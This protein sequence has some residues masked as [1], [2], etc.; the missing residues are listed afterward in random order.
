MTKKSK[1][2]DQV[3]AP[4]E[5][6][7]HVT[8]SQEDGSLTEALP[9]EPAG[10][11][12][13]KPGRIDR[14]AARLGRFGHRAAPWIEKVQPWPPYLAFLVPLLVY[15]PWIR[16]QFTFWDTA[17][18][19]TAVI[20][21][22]VPHPSGYPLYVMLGHLASLLPF[23]TQHIAVAFCMATVPSALTSWFIYQML[24]RLRMPRWPA[25]A[26]CFFYV[27]N[28]DVVYHSTKVE[29]Y[30]F[31]VF[32]LSATLYCILRWVQERETKWAYLAVLANCLALGGH[33]TSVTMI[34][35]TVAALLIGDWRRMIHP[36]RVGILLLIAAACACIY[37]YL[38]WSASTNHGDKLTWSDPQT[39]EMFKFHVTGEQYNGYRKINHFQRGVL[40]FLHKPN[41]QI[42]F[43]VWLLCLLGFYEGLKTQWK[44]FIPLGIYTMAMLTYVATYDI[45]DIAT[46]YPALILPGVIL[47]AIGGLWLL[48]ARAP[49]RPGRGRVLYRTVVILGL[50]VCFGSA[51]WYYR[52]EGYREGTLYD[53]SRETAKGV[54]EANGILFTSV[55][56]HS[57]SMWYQNYVEHPDRKLITV[58]LTTSGSKWYRDH[59]RERYPQLNWPSEAIWTTPKFAEWMIENNPNYR[60]FSLMPKKWDKEGSTSVIRGWY[61]EILRK[62]K[63]QP[64]PPFTQYARHIYMGEH[65]RINRDHYFYDARTSFPIGMDNLVC[66]MD[67]FDE[68]PEIKPQWIFTGPNGAKHEVPVHPVPVGSNLSWDFLPVEKQVPGKWTCEV[69]LEGETPLI[70]EFELRPK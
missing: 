36:K 35:A 49:S 2:P 11:E 26:A 39:W 3:D 55:D 44:F 10:Q 53:L 59:L 20:T 14:I 47:G 57:F 34:P 43:G 23:P 65:K 31:H 8:M 56:N 12:T 30:S 19:L 54:I 41:T 48:R 67:W 27:F 15:I 28:P 7:E 69:K 29:V 45:N 5:A 40:N 66:V 4:P 6:A 64:D 58:D 9:A 37:L 21:L 42:I 68:K 17:E 32:L 16:S 13:K 24:V 52:G 51:L 50:L 38:P 1:T 25:L 61:H 60:F 70:T 62:Q 63:G 22:G 46:Y 18:I 33:L